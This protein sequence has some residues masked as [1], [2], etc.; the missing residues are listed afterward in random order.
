MAGSRPQHQAWDSTPAVQTE[1][2]DGIFEVDGLA[3]IEFSRKNWTYMLGGRE[4][5]GGGYEAFATCRWCGENVKAGGGMG[6]RTVI[7]WGWSHQCNK[8]KV[9]YEVDEDKRLFRH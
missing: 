3:H 5:K 8:D 9:E 2:V 7:R 6:E 4:V 1:V